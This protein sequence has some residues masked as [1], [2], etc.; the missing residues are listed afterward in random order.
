MTG[1]M[2]LSAAVTEL[3]AVAL[4]ALV[5]SATDWNAATSLAVTVP[6]V[7]AFSYWFLPRAMGLWVG[8]EFLTDVGNRDVSGQAED[9]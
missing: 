3:F 7:I 6:L 5:W 9:A 1:Q 2:Y 4:I 8:I